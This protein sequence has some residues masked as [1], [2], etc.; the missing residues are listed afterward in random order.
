MA[1]PPQF[2]ILNHAAVDSGIP[3]ESATQRIGIRQGLPRKRQKGDPP[4]SLL[5]R[6]RW[7]AAVVEHIC[8]RYDFDATRNEATKEAGRECGC[9]IVAEALKRLGIK[10]LGESQVATIW[11]QARQ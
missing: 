3:R 11:R 6:D 7:I 5:L 10:R 1:N 4:D 2:A 8:R 9:S